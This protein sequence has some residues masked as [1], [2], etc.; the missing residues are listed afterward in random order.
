LLKQGC[1]PRRIGG[2]LRGG[3]LGNG[4]FRRMVHASSV[5][6]GVEQRQCALRPVDM[7]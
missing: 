7:N 1:S 2:D 6:R 3:G 4:A 5:Y